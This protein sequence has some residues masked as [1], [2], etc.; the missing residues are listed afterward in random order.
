MIKL[1]GRCGAHAEAYQLVANSEKEYGLKP[2]VMH[3]TCLM[4]GCLH[5]KKYEKAWAAFEL[6]IEHGV[7]PDS[8]TME[9]LLPGMVNAQKWDRVMNLARRSLEPDTEMPV[10]PDKLNLALSQIALAQGQQHH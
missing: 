4:S 3:Y 10:A 5:A 9:I 6:M 8:T 1:H 7:S 2:T